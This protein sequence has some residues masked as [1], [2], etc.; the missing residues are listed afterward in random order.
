MEIAQTLCC[1]M[2]NI[3]VNNCGDYLQVGFAAFKSYIV[4]DISWKD[5]F[6]HPGKYVIVS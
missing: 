1:S 4:S 3:I 2:T 6:Q 5:I